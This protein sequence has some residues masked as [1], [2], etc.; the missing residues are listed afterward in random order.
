M[1]TYALPKTLIAQRPCRP[2]DSARLLVV[3]REKGAVP[4][5]VSHRTFRDLPRLL[6]PN[7]CLILN[8]TRV[9]PARLRGQRA[10]TGGKVELLLLDRYDVPEGPLVRRT[11]L[12]DSV[13]RCLGQ[14]GRRL[15]PG[16]R[17]LLNHGSGEAEVVGEDGAE[18][19]VR[20]PD[21]AA[22]EWMERFGEVPLPPYV[23][24]PV[25]PRDRR[26]YQTVY[27]RQPGAVA[28]PTAGLHFTRRLLG[29]IERK[30]VRV[31]FLTLHVGWGTFRPVGEEQLREGKLHPESFWIPA[32]TLG[33]IGR[34]RADGGRVIAVGTTVAR[35]LETWAITGQAAGRTNLFIRPGFE[36]RVVDA[37]VTNFHL[38]GTSLLLLVSAFAGEER[39]LAAYGEAVRRRYR[40]Y[41]Y[42]DAMLIV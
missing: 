5:S 39:A 19:L 26:W 8:D 35:A 23:R 37:L 31:H 42:G 15:R 14:P 7:D 30:S 11:G 38:P 9:I 34:A 25:E 16:T 10:D 20:F 17:L 13:W 33:A 21:G 3:Q 18:R 1:L 27:A 40:F 24:R 12:G 32:E 29:R 22:E 4:F 2:R 41:S 28:A 36:F 6:Q